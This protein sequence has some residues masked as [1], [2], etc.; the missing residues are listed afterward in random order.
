MTL[1]TIF[2]RSM[3]WKGF[4]MAS[5]FFVTVFFARTLQ[6]AMSAELY[7]LVYILSL[8]TGFFTLG[9]DVGLNYFVSRLE[10]DLTGARMLICV[11]MAA[12]LL[13]GG[14]LL[15]W[16][17]SSGLY[18]D[19]SSGRFLL[20]SALQVSGAL[21]VTLSGALFTACGRNHFPA[22]LA[23]V[24]NGLLLVGILVLSRVLSP[25]R[26]PES[27]FFLY[28]GAVFLQGV[29]LLIASARLSPAAGRPRD[30]LG[31]DRS[32]KRVPLATL[33]RFSLSAFLVNYVFLIAGRMGIYL[34]PGRVPASV[35]G[36]YIQAY[37]MVEYLG[38]VPGFFYFPFISLVVGDKER[39]T[40]KLLFLVRL[41]N[42]LAAGFA[43]SVVLLGWFLF[44]FL[45]GPSFRD[46]YGFFIGFIP[47]LFPVCA[48]GYFTAYF[49][50]AG[51]LRLNGISAGL[52]L[53]ASVGLFFLLT[54]VAGAKGS[55]LAYSG[56]AL[57]SMGFDAWAFRR[58]CPFRLR[59]ILFLRREDLAGVKVFIARLSGR[60]DGN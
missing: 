11:V 43:L 48:A 26:L 10:L 49:Y 27:L 18:P 6:S 9:L 19:L 25:G 4:Q 45:F 57:L 22:M 38:L 15:L 14:P 12:A 52:Q 16:Y 50:G 40:G 24:A 56:A 20:L 30:P 53:V 1:G 8:V 47:G 44:P 7:S 36:N 23:T 41:S 58:F 29:V 39:M 28:F 3:V 54:P 34:L 13:V 42:T 59:D 31:G 51:Q 33:L 32:G 37:K 55:A 5:S 35:L 46:M 2:Y 60:R 17:H 21:A